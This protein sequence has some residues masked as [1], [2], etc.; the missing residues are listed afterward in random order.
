MFKKKEYKHLI[1][2]MLTAS[3]K[4]L[5]RKSN[6]IKLGKKTSTKHSNPPNE[7]INLKT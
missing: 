1:I 4:T 2:H 7:I 6:R 3:I 5:K